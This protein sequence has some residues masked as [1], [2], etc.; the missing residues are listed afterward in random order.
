MATQFAFEH[1][2]HAP[3]IDAVFA[4]YF[5]PAHLIA[6]DRVLEIV[7][8]QVIEQVDD[9]AVLRRICKVTPRRQLPAIVR[10]FVDGSLH[11]L[12]KATWHR[13]DP[14]IEVEIWPS[15]LRRKARPTVTALYRLSQLP[16]GGIRRSYEGVVSVDLA[17]LSSRIER[18]IVAE[19]ERSVPIAATCT[20][21]YLNQTRGSVS[22]RA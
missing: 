9:G 12:E 18:G 11:Y 2:F 3:S 13:A 1:V 5:D 4:A 7:D 19:F 14:R 16:G 6:Q 20:Q 17:L 22:A 21:A 8:R 10:P 15:F